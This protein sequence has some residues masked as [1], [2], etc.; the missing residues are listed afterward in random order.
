MTRR[1]SGAKRPSV[2]LALDALPAALAARLNDP[3][4]LDVTGGEAQLWRVRDSAH[5]K[6]QRV[7]KVYHQAIEP[8]PVVLSRLRSIRS[9]H[10]I[11]IVESGT[12]LDDRFFEL[13][14]YFPAGSLR[15]R[16]NVHG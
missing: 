4:A 16:G 5:P 8:N 10:V 3:Q 14:E 1:E 11:E 13:M 9:P 12:L 2:V 6:A 15:G 7:L